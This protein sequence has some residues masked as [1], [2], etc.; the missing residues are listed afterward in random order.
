MTIYVMNRANEPLVWLDLALHFPQTGN[1]RTEPTRIYHIRLGRMPDVDAFYGNGDHIPATLI[2]T[3]PLDLQPGATLA[4]HVS[5]HF[6]KIQ[7][8]VEKVMPLTEINECYIYTAIAEFDG[9]LR[10][11]GG[12]YSLPDKQHP[13]QWHY[14]PTRQYFPGNAHQYLPNIAR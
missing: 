7:A 8:Y 1:G 9:G 6:D 3:K 11:T 14:L 10:Y 12:N 13:G 2:G 4:I 5:G